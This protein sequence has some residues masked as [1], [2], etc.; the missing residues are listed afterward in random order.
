M[1]SFSVLLHPTLQN[2]KTEGNQ[3]MAA[4]LAETFVKETDHS[5][6]LR[7]HVH[8]LA[9]HLSRRRN[10]K[11]SCCFWPIQKRKMESGATSKSA[12]LATPS[13]TKCRFVM[14]L[15]SINQPTVNKSRKAL[16][17]GRCH[18]SGVE[19]PR[20]KRLQY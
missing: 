10:L 1:L 15:K 13:T 8:F 9:Q 3:P 4:G 6:A 5:R 2:S 7:R 12:S 18:H 11:A 19:G 20:D 16:Q 14:C 17:H